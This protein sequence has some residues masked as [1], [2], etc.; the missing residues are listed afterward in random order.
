MLHHTAVRLASFGFR[1]PYA[2]KN[3][4]P[5]APSRAG[6]A[7]HIQSHPHAAFAGSQHHAPCNQRTKHQ[8]VFLLKLQLK[9][10]KHMPLHAKA[11]AP[12]RDA[13]SRSWSISFSSFRR[14]SR[15]A[16]SSFSTSDSRACVGKE[17][18]WHK[19]SS[20]QAVTSQPLLVSGLWPWEGLTHGKSLTGLTGLPP[21]WQACRGTP[22]MHTAWLC[23]FVQ[24]DLRWCT[25]YHYITA[26][27][28]HVRE[29]QQ[30]AGWCSWT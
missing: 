16:A 11:H 26:Q 14:A 22:H 8:R 6:K 25:W 2:A 4:C 27:L 17:R 20:R 28:P 10:P 15:S 13:L 24:A 18:Q 23:S 1:P 12:P 29:Q 9:R 30:T 7:S 5:G 21:G 19:A 3:T